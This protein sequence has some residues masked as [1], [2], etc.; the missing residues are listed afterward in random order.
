MKIQVF[1]LTVCTLIISC[2]KKAN[3]EVDK[4][5][6]KSKNEKTIS[7]SSSYFED[8]KNNEVIKVLTS[9]VSDGDTLAYRKLKD[10]FFYSG[11]VKEFLYNAILMSDR[12]NYPSADYDV[13]TILYSSRY[14]ESKSSKLANYYLFK[15]YEK[16]ANH[17]ESTI[18]ERFGEKFKVPKSK[19]YWIEI[20]Q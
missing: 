8:Y 4:E 9:K 16:N 5:V 20:N 13:Y 3:P 18:K 12:H 10:I 2:N 6:I 17:A 7:P 1:I 14:P 19:A 15:A 11:H